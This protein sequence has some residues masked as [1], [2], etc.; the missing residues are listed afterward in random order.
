MKWSEV[1]SYHGTQTGVAVKDGRAI[2]VICGGLEHADFVSEKEIRYVVPT[3]P[4][5]LKCT[6]ALKTNA[7]DGSD[8][9]VFYKVRPNDWQDL[10]RFK[11]SEFEVREKDVL[12]TFRPISF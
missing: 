6:L 9:S 4:A 1:I 12:F 2:S 11:V 3:R 10:G 7:T 8:F 5:Y